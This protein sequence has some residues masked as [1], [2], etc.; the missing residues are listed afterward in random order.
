M[1]GIIYSI[2][3][4]STKVIYIGSTKQPINVRKS[5]HIYDS[6]IIKRMKPVHKF[7]NENGTWDNY[8]FS[9]IVEEDFNSIIELR[10]KERKII[11]DYKQNQDY[12]LL[13]SNL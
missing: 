5:K 8:Q 9:I 4:L 12:I 1:K 11:E 2:K 13:N 6:K 7:V 3:S 10:L